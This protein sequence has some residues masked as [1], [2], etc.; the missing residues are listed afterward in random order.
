M[1]VYQRVSGEDHGSIKLVLHTDEIDPDKV[2]L[3]DT[4]VVEVSV[5]NLRN[6]DC[7]DS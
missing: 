1:L 7:R 4:A 6:D 3:L 5:K 2:A